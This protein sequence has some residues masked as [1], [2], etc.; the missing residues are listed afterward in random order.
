MT[1]PA[2]P[3]PAAP[4]PA[5]PVQELPACHEGGEPADDTCVQCGRPTCALHFYE[6]EHL[7][8]C[9]HCG[10]E[11]VGVLGRG[12]AM[13]GWPYPLRKPFESREPEA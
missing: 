11:L 4:G 2:T 3:G 6:Q 7:G 5:T 12:G 1:D 8:L 10:A 9:T 13:I